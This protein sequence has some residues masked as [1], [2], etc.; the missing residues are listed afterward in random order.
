MVLDVG[1]NRQIAGVV[2]QG[3]YDTDNKRVTSYYVD[4]S[5][6]NTNWTNVDS[7]ALFVENTDRHTK[8]LDYLV[9]LLQRI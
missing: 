7:A 1:S 3:R 4:Y 8:S 6:D 2:T 9:Q 5:T